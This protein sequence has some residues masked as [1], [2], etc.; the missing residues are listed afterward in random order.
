[1]TTYKYINTTNEILCPL[2]Q[3]DEYMLSSDG[4]KFTCAACG[5]HTKNF[6]AVQSAQAI[7]VYQRKPVHIH[8]ISTACH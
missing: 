4:E 2:C 5:F 1:M 6:S 7:P 3:N 8:T